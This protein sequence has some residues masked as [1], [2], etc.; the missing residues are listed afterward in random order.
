MAG[1]PLHDEGL[2]AFGPFV[3][4][5]SQRVLW[6]DRELLRLTPREIDVLVALVERHGEIV[7]KSRFFDQVWRGLAVEECNLSQHVAGLRRALGDDARVPTYIETLPRRG[8]RF[9]APVANVD[10]SSVPVWTPAPQPALHDPGASAPAASGAPL[11]APA[12]VATADAPPSPAI[13]PAAAEIRRGRKPPR[14]TAW[15][16]PAAVVV[17]GVLGLGAGWKV[18]RTHARIPS[19]AG[20]SVVVQPFANLTGDAHHDRMAETL[21][22]ELMN[23]LRAV[24]GLRVE[25]A[26]VP[27]T[28]RQAAGVDAIVESSLL[29][30]EGRIRLTAEIIDAKT[31]RLAWAEVY[32]SD[33]VSFLETEDRIAQTIVARLAAL[34]GDRASEGASDRA[35]AQWECALAREFLSRR[36]P[37]VV[38]EALAHFT[39]A[40]ER[41]RGYA[42]AFVGMADAYLL[43]AEERALGPEEALAGAEA[44]AKRA[45]ELDPRLAEAHAV[46]GA[47]AAARWDFDA[48]EAS[49]QRALSLDAS[50][51]TVHE[52]YADLLTVRDRHEQAIAEARVARDLAPTCP[53]AATTLAETYYHSG[54]NDAAI[55]QALGALR[56]TPGFAAA[57]D[58]LGWAYQAKGQD[59]EAVAAFQQAVRLSGSS[60]T[61][62]AALARAHA[63][64]GSPD[65]ARKLLSELERRP[66]DRRASRL[67]V[68][69]IL[70][71]LGETEKAVRQVERAV[72][73][74]VPWLPHVDSGLSLTALHDH[75]RFRALVTRMRRSGAALDAGAGA[76]AP[77]RLERS[78]S[79]G[80][81]LTGASALVGDKP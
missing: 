58:V 74:G 62:V 54:Q 55:D 24:P 48:A 12:A 39:A 35:A 59:A 17:L 76:W 38:R 52:R 71:A 56:H 73:E 81:R 23:D 21:T 31:K 3:L 70:A 7:E 45:L 67:D 11:T 72:A 2:Y 63:R 37:H 36:T 61:Y 78:G 13:G 32:D 22:A 19:L 34:E 27:A 75:A 6:R 33:P 51:A 49:Y 64:G 46:L 29:S 66:R 53:S 5:A 14:R 20:R 41:D 28:E 68:A 65:E 16:A 50:I 4:D 42:P 79:A 1:D 47:V 18:L 10:R 30:A 9:V 8:Y 77:A 60:P 26:S 44:A 40:A 43:G 80:S 15:L 57:Y 69:E 25:V